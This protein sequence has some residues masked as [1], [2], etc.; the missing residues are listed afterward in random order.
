MWPMFLTLSILTI[1]VALAYIFFDRQNH[2][3][4]IT[5]MNTIL[6]S[7]FIA[8]TLMFIPMYYEMFKNDAEIIT[9]LKTILI[10]MHHAIRLFIVDSDFEIIRSA[11]P[12]INNY[13]YYTYTTYAAILFLLSPVMTFGFIFSFFKNMSAHR[14]YL[15]NYN[16]DVFVFSEF[17]EES[18]ELAASIKTEFDN[19]VV[20]FTNSYEDNPIYSELVEKA[21]IMKAIVFEKDIL[22]LNFMNHS[23]KKNI[24]FLLIGKDE[25]TNVKNALG[26]IKTY[27]QR[28]NTQMYV[29][30][31]DIEGELL[32]NATD[33]GEIKI[34]R[35]S[36]I[37]T[38][39]YSILQSKGEKLFAE[40]TNDDTT[41]KKLISAIIIGLGRYGSEMTKSLTW[42]CQ[43]EGYKIEIDV[44]DVNSS[45]DKCFINTCPELMDDSHNNKFDDPGE[46]Q[47]RITM[48]TPTDVNSIEFQ[49]EIKKLN[50]TT[51]VFI[52]LGDDERNISTSIKLRM[53]FE[54]MGIKPRIQAIVENSERK[55]AL[56]GIKNYS[57]QP[58]D[59]E[60]VGAINE[61][62]SYKSIINSELEQEA[63]ERHLCWGEEIDF[64]K[65]EYNYRSS[66]ASALHKR[67]KKICNIPGIEKKPSERTPEETQTLRLME[68]RR[69]NAY[70]RSEGYIYSPQRN[71]LAKTHHCLVT[72]DMLSQ[73]DKEKD[74]D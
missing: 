2:K 67:M 58:Y 37:R 72:F 30:S 14:K 17:N 3:K 48:H 22:R 73:K 52:A 66:M 47:Y 53:I 10:S 29:L 5:P 21:K 12:K 33:T 20:V 63:L 74:D 19:C 13:F 15:K 38:T 57:G 8:N 64:W 51:Y 23:K 56:S 34:R 25:M 45:A 70:M 46:A 7:V 62:Y 71:N 16:K 4:L 54:Q 11:V 1:F 59:I 26:I 6:C 39:I 40:A 41:D 68:H 31:N 43:M 27:K 32:L 60:Y 65:Y 35:I 50:K 69:W 24:N 28:K 36:N 42:F 49:N 55:D 18:V 61:I 9:G 44:F